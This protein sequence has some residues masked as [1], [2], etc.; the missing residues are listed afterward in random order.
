MKI[1]IVGGGSFAWT[2]ALVG[3]FMLNEFF[4]GCEICLMDINATALEEVVRRLELLRP[5]AKATLN[6]ST[7]TSLQEGVKNASYVIPAVAVGGLKSTIRD[8]EIGRELGFW[9]IK[10]HDIGPAG[11]SRTLRHVPFLVHLARLMEKFSAPNAMLLNVTNPLVA[12]TMGVYVNSSVKAYGFCHGVENHLEA[13]LPLFG[14]AS[15]DEVEFVTTGVDHCSWLLDI[16]VNG[17]DALEMMRGNGLIEAA[18]RNEIIITADDPFAG[19]EAERLR[20]VIWDQ[21]GYFPAISDDHICEFFPQFLKNREL[22]EHWGMTYDRI[23]ERENTIIA[24]NKKHQDL[25]TGKTK[26]SLS[27]SGE[28]IAQAIAAFH[29]QGAFIGVLNAPN[30]GQIAN[31]PSGV[32]AETKCLIGANGVQPIT[33]GP[34]P[35]ILEAIVRP[36]VLHEKLYMEAAYSWNKEKALAALSTDPIVNDFVNIK[37][38]VDK[39]F[40]LNEKVLEE[41]GIPIASWQ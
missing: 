21:I 10:G 2:P 15:M 29:G 4:N 32:I 11:F 22:S 31:L 28:I 13:L 9:N 35:D 27:P 6:I 7:T 3:D 38:M 33:A 19:K 12:N 40:A 26:E 1:T 14:V 41:I 39:Y 36:I 16:K 25:L 20:F 8:H 17:C 23:I 34:L 30:I 5:Y 18:Y 24:T 37:V